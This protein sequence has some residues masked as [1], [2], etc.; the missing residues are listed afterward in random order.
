MKVSVIMPVYLGE[1]EGCATNREDKF[2]RA[3]NSFLQNNLSDSELIIVSD[4]CLITKNI[5][6]DKF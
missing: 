3:V 1:Y 4:D 6:N 5:V 2:I